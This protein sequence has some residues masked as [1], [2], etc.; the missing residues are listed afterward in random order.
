MHE[1]TPALKNIIPNSIIFI[2]SLYIASKDSPLAFI[3]GSGTTILGVAL[4]LY[5]NK[6]RTKNAKKQ[7]DTKIKKP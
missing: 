7:N 5:I 6:L 1:L 4:F 3:A 2:T